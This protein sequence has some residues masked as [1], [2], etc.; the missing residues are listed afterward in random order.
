MAEKQAKSK[1]NK[2]EVPAIPSESEI[3]SMGAEGIVNNDGE[4]L[5]IEDIAKDLQESAYGL[6]QTAEYFDF[7]MGEERRILYVDDTTIKSR[8]GDEIPAV[9]FFVAEDKKFGINASAVLVS[10]VQ[11]HRKMTKF[12]VTKTGEEKSK[13]GTYYKYTIYDLV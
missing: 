7:P 13:D 11:S 1:G 12:S 4:Q 10:T 2:S 9:K 6:E 5:G 8:T 3:Q